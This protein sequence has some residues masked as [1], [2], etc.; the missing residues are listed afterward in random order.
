[1]RYKSFAIVS[2]ILAC[3]RR[4][5][6]AISLVACPN[7]THVRMC[8]YVCIHAVPMAIHK[9]V[10]LMVWVRVL[11]GHVVCV[12]SA[13]VANVFDR[14]ARSGGCQATD[15]SGW[16]TCPDSGAR[17]QKTLMDKKEKWCVNVP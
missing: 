16:F 11:C 7:R 5:R 6:R 12:F 2:A 10:W 9:G 15:Q 1:M 8:V 17:F 14:N 3:T 13:D 4:M